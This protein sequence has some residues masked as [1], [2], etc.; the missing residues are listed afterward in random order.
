[1]FVWLRF[2]GMFRPYRR[3]LVVVFLATLARPLLNAVKI[4]L[5]KLIVDNLAAHPTSGL[6]LSICGAYLAIAFAKGI[7]NYGDEYLGVW[8]GGRVTLDLRERVFRRLLRLSLRYHGEHRV[9]ESISRLVSDVGAVEG[10]LISGLTDGLA[11]ALTVV[12]YTVILFY[13][14]PMLALL[15]LLIIP[16]LFGALAVYAR[17]SRVAFH[18]VRERLSELTGAVEESLS[19][20]ALVKSFARHDHATTRLNER[21]K[22]HWRARVQ[23]ARQRAFFVPL[24]DVIATVGTTLVVYFGAQALKNGTLTIGGLVIFLAYLGQLYNPLL[25]LSR[26]GASL[27][28]GAAAAERVISVLHLPEDADEPAEATLPWRRDPT[29]DGVRAKPAATPTPAVVFDHVSFHYE[30]GRPILRDFTLVAPR[31]KVVALVGPSGAG[32]S[33]AIALL[34]RLYEPDK[35][36]IL[37]FGHDI[38]E[39]DTTALRRQFAVVAQEPTLLMGSVGENIAYGDLDA[40][41]ET[42]AWAAEQVG[43]TEM[44]LANGLDTQVGPRGSLLSGGQRQRVAMARALVRNAPILLLDEATSALDALS[45]Q[46]LRLLIE[47]LRPRHTVIVVAHRLSTV[48]DADVIAVVEQGHVVESGR[49]DELLA[50]NGAYAALVRSQLVDAEP[51]SAAGDPG[52]DTQIGPRTLPNA[53]ATKSSR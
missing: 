39:A 41:P 26:L 27:Q 44:G 6:A 20:I 17:R 3:R 43:I 4:Y 37:V 10:A 8:V 29:P 5:L 32:K 52:V 22:L 28:G 33:T 31:G 1:M 48:R 45:E 49:H 35:G 34:Q 42:I 51:S 40:P 11:Q 25:N 23:A 19:T 13:L 9:G 36:R 2:L 16:F 15:S 7:A 38:R 50:R 18:A 30:S 24:S 46:R 47:R 53:L 14:D 12:V 21:G